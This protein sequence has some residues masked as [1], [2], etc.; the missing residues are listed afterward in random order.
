MFIIPLSI[1]L[2]LTHFCL[3]K[4]WVANGLVREIYVGAFGSMKNKN[5]GDERKCVAKDHS[6][7]KSMRNIYIDAEKDMHLDYLTFA[8][9]FRHRFSLGPC[10]T[11]H[12]TLLVSCMN[13]ATLN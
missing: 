7:K 13:K 9:I 11:F 2:R 3:E 12:N 8:I 10:C 5:F 1:F 6:T 4:D